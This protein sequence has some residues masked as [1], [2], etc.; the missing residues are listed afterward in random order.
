MDS[1]RKR[2]WHHW[3]PVVLLD[4]LA[5]L[6]PWLA[7]LNLALEFDKG[8]IRSIEAPSQKRRN[9]KKHNRILQGTGVG[10]MKLGGFEGTHIC[11]MRLV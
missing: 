10:D 4:C 11:C 5:Y 3:D 7:G 2:D 9:I 6:A 8:R 1:Q